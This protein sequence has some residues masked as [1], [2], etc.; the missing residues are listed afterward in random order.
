MVVVTHYQRLLNYIVPD[1]VHVLVEGR[2]VALRRARRWRSSSRRRATPGWRRSRRRASVTAMSLAARPRA[3][4]I[5][6]TSCGRAST[7]SPSGAASSDV[8]WLALL[9]TAAMARFAERGFP[10]T[11]EEAWRLHER[12]PHRP[13][14]VPGAGRGRP[15]RRSVGA[16]SG[17]RRDPG[18]VRQR[19]L[20][21]GALFVPWHSL[22]PGVEV[23]SLRDVLA[24]EPRRLE[25][26]LGPAVGPGERVRRP[27]HR[28]SWRTGRSSSWP[29]RR[30]PGS[31]SR[32][33]FS[34]PTP[35]APPRCR[36]RG[37]CWWPLPGASASRRA[38]RRSRGARL[39]HERRHRGRRG[40]GRLRRPLV[41]QREQP[42]RL[43]RVIP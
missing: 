26:L 11:R 7:D 9:R 10:T 12:G 16:D 1:F 29:R 15:T 40:G 38:L 13:H 8:P 42:R 3:T 23:A 43:P 24:R 36:P 17:F 14:R 6:R 27:E 37:S 4:A 34:P 25:P 20:L 28:A 18:R 21:R 35:T 31:P 5:P 41:V 2:I 33:L 19:P 39:L 22:P 30:W 32:S